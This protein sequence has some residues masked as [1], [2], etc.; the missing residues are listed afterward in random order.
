MVKTSTGAES[1][2]ARQRVVNAA[3]AAEVQAID[4]VFTA[5]SATSRAAGLG[6]ILAGL[7]FEGMGCVHPMQIEVIHDAFAPTAT[8]IET[9]AEDCRRLQE[10]S[11]GGSEW[12][13][14]ARR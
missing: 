13:A 8:E 14:W 11:R 2:Y 9:S 6:R 3:H 10:P 12:S 5:M 7:G 1:L 4:S